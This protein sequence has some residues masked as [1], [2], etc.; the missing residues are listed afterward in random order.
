METNN[1]AVLIVEHLKK[2]YSKTKAV[3]DVSFSVKRGE[4]I[5]IIGP[6]GAGKST[7]LRCINRLIDPTDGKII[8][9]GNDITSKKGNEII[10]ARRRIGMI[11]QHFNL[12]YRLSVF[13]N[14]MHGRLGYIKTLDGVLSRY[15]E[16]DKQ[17]ALKIIRQI[18]LEETIYKRASELSGGQKQRV[19]IARALMQDPALLLCDEPIASL[20][21]STSKVIMELIRDVTIQN[22]I[23]CIVNLHQVDVAVHYCTRIIGIRNGL[24]VY[25]GP[26]EGLKEE[27]I[28]D[29]YCSSPIVRQKGD[30]AV[31]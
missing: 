5:A 12:V 17:K 30:E 19:G 27:V 24:V 14:I 21:P 20:D 13:Q 3:E 10:K 16:E 9:E 26:P 25:D 31:G 15:Q 1:E 2:Y 18:G 29:I 8:F 22:N 11:F 7:I 28:N 4:I 23:A 6:S